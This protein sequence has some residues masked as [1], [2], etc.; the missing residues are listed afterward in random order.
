DLFPNV[1]LNT[2]GTKQLN[3][4][5]EEKDK[6]EVDEGSVT[7]MSY[8]AYTRFGF[9]EEKYTE[10]TKEIKDQITNP[11]KE[12]QKEAG[13][14]KGDR[15][16]AIEQ[17]KVEAIIGSANV[18]TDPRLHFDKSGFDHITVDEAHNFNNIFTSPKNTGTSRQSNEYEG[19][20]GGNS[21]TRGLKLWLTSREVLKNN[22]NRNIMLLT[23]TP[24]TN[25]PLQVYSLISLMAK[26][27]LEEMGILNIH[28]FVSAFVDVQ[29]EYVMEANGKI[30]NT[31]TARGFK[32]AKAF[33][34][35]INEFFDYKTGEDGGINRPDLI[36]KSILL[37]ETEE[38]K[39]NR[40]VLEGLFDAKDES[41]RPLPGAALKSIGNQ[42]LQNISPALLKSISMDE[43]GSKMKGY[44]Q[45]FVERSPKVKFALDSIVKFYN[46]FK[47]RKP[48][49]P[50]PGQICF[51]PKGVEF[52]K[53]MKSYLIAKGIPKDAVGVMTPKEKSAKAKD[54]DKA[55]EGISQFTEMT[56]DFNN[57]A[58]KLKIIIGSD[59]IKEGVDLNGNTAVCYNLMTAWNPTDEQQKLGRAW[60]QGNLQSRVHFVDVQIEDSID[61][62]LYQKQAEKA[63]RI[64]DI[65]AD[66]GGNA[67]DTSDVN[68]DEVKLDVITDPDRKAQ[69]ALALG[70]AEETGKRQEKQ[71]VIL[72]MQTA[73]EE[74]EKFSSSAEYN[75]KEFL[76][77]EKK[78][79]DL[80]P[81][82]KEL[83]E[84]VKQLEKDGKKT[85]EEYEDAVYEYEDKEDDLKTYKKRAS[86]Y[87]QKLRTDQAKLETIKKKFERYGLPEDPKTA[88]KFINEEQAKLD[89]ERELDKAS[90]E[91]KLIELKE[92]YRKERAEIEESKKKRGLDKLDTLV[93]NHVNEVLDD[94]LGVKRAKSLLGKAASLYSEKILE[95]N[96][97]FKSLHK[98]KRNASDI[99]LYHIFLDF[100]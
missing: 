63:S 69:M 77:Y 50:V 22:N 4:M 11:D 47:N 49:E 40:A 35:L 15:A 2:I 83:R 73:L 86:E 6:F 74:H 43:K 85:T 31:N 71:L 27:R 32:N 25:N 100:T 98:R 81:I 23:A 34:K 59:V 68:P 88:E 44:G 51:L 48:G 87:K 36:R 91:Q 18:G 97:S 75:E 55:S 26:E 3:K 12:A 24:F 17:E 60:R 58:G 21:S 92:R 37:P 95:F 8:D 42:Q 96:N 29:Q 30:K 90:N 76:Y 62:K 33:R 20:T 39:Q 66:S 46:E 10:L 54:P 9:S 45:N 16:A 84:K 99:L 1:P 72:S 78:A 19:I 53:D 67:I 56:E 80:M 52:T 79:S 70:I 7:I 57:P 41:G 64:N 38:M 5:L 65:F 61:T 89:K 28:D 93:T 13:G 94:I 14:K 82:V